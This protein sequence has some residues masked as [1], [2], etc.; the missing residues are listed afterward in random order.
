MCISD[1]DLSFVTGYEEDS[2]DY[3]IYVERD[4]DFWNPS[5]NWSVY[6]LADDEEVEVSDGY[7][8]TPSMALHEAR[9]SAIKIFGQ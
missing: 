9:E 2:D 5:F 6:R 1:F 4:P 8:M 3:R 7:A